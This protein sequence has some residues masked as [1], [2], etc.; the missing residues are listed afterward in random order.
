ML[1]SKNITGNL[2]CPSFHSEKGKFWLWKDPEKG[3]LMFCIQASQIITQCIRNLHR[4]NWERADKLF[5]SVIPL[6]IKASSWELWINFFF[7]LFL[8]CNV[9][10]WILRY[11][12]GD[13]CMS[14]F[15][16]SLYSLQQ[17]IL[18]TRNSKSSP[19]KYGELNNLEK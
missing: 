18:R 13:R 5:V 10:I 7:L 6:I 16:C 4:Y 1:C 15:E 11:H 2:L 9:S 12:E 14:E 3:F 8:N 17:H 19:N